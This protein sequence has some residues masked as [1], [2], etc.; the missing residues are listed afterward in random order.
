MWLGFEVPAHSD[1]ES[2]FHL[3][4][5]GW[6]DPSTVF[7]KNEPHPQRKL[8]KGAYRCINPVSLVDQLV[9]ACLFS[10]MANILKSRIYE[11]GSALGIGFSDD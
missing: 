11:S 5:A 3:L 7:I 9:E 2:V 8:K 1:C 4:T 6:K 10:E